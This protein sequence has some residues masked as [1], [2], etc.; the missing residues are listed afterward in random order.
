[1]GVI[2]RFRCPTDR[3]MTVGYVRSNGPFPAEGYELGGMSYV[4]WV[5]G[6]IFENENEDEAE[7]HGAE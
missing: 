3:W 6:I 5:A 1:M 7:Q 2:F 4:A